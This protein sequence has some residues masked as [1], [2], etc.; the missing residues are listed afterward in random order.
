VKKL[1]VFSLC[2]I[3]MLLLIGATASASSVPRWPE[4]AWFA[5]FGAQPVPQPV[6]QSVL[7]EPVGQAP[8]QSAVLTAEERI[9]FDG[10]NRE[11]VS[12]G[13]KPLTV[14]PALV[15]LARKKSQDFINNNYFAHRSPI[16]GTAAEM[17]RAAGIRY[18]YAGE[19]IARTS[20]P[21]NAIAL[22]MGSSIHR[23]ALLNPRYSQT[24]IGIVRVGRQIYVTQMFI[25]FQQ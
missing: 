20:T 3:F 10:I 14:N 16:Y 11:R 4:P 12:R 5:Q 19:N 22:F 17:M 13:L 2:I 18:N 6:T 24:G 15:E 9:V 21:E 8:A 23:S 25:G 1:S 7:Q